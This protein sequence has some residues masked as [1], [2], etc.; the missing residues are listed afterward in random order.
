MKSG[1][2][3]REQRTGDAYRDGVTLPQSIREALPR[4]EENQALRDM[5]GEDFCKVYEASKTKK[6]KSS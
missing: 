3:P 2:K 4:F 5:L 1:A 6:L